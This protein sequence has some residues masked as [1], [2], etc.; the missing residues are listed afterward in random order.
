MD[1]NIGKFFS[2]TVYGVRYASQYSKKT[3]EI[4]STYGVFIYEGN[5]EGFPIDEENLTYVE[6]EINSTF[7]RGYKTVDASNIDLSLEDVTKIIFW[8]HDY[9]SKNDVPDINLYCYDPNDNNLYQ[10]FLAYSEIIKNNYRF[11]NIPCYYEVAKYDELEDV[12]VEV[13]AIIREDGSYVLNPAGYCDACVLFLSKEEWDNLPPIPD[14][15]DPYIRYSFVTKTWED[16]RTIDELSEQYRLTVEQSFDSALE[17]NARYY[18]DIQTNQGKLLIHSLGIEIDKTSEN[19]N[20]GKQS[21]ADLFMVSTTTTSTDDFDRDFYTEQLK[22]SS[23]IIEGQKAMWLA[24]PT[25][26]KNTVMYDTSTTTGWK[27]LLYKFVEWYNNTYD[28][29]FPYI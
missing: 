6:C 2:D 25:K 27:N 9:F 3:L 20:Y 17:A 11:T 14:E 13:Y 12:W 24:L 26:I 8:I 5:F 19:Y 16:T 10:G 7:Q 28:Q 23:E 22:K 15:R 21:V 18:Y 1:Q 4:F 29:T